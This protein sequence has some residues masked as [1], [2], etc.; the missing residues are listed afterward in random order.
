M[1]KLMTM[2]ANT[3]AT[4]IAQGMPIGERARLRD[5]INTEL[6]TN[7]ADLS[8]ADADATTAL[9]LALVD[10]TV[11]VARSLSAAAQSD[12][13]ESVTPEWR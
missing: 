13:Q 4:V 10:L 12:S 7:D 11:A 8:A 2:A 1:V 5:E 6:L 9:A 3:A